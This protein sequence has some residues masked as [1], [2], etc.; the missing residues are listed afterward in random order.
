MSAPNLPPPATEPD[1]GRNLTREPSEFPDTLAGEIA[2]RTALKFRQLRGERETFEKLVIQRSD[3][4][5][6]D[7][8]CGRAR[9]ARLVVKHD[10]QPGDLIAITAFGED[11]RG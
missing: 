9:L 8:L 7:V 5:L 11:E 2:S 1:D 3:G 6:I 4:E 10:P